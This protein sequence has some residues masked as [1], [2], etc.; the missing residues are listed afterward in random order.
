MRCSPF[1]WK[2]I[3]SHLED[4]RDRSADV[5]HPV[6]GIDA[7]L[8]PMHFFHVDEEVLPLQ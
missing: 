1:T 7:Y 3:F 5:V 4:V 6:A 8:G 2:N